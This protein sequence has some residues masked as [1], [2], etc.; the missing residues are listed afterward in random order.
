MDRSAKEKANRNERSARDYQLEGFLMFLSDVYFAADQYQIDG[1][2]ELVC[3]KMERVLLKELYEMSPE[4]TLNLLK[5]FYSVDLLNPIPIRQL[6]SNHVLQSD[7]EALLLDTETEAVFQDYPEIL[8]DVFKMFAKD[9]KPECEPCGRS[10]G[11]RRRRIPIMAKA[12]VRQGC[13][14]DC[15]NSS[16]EASDHDHEIVVRSFYP[17]VKAFKD[18]NEYKLQKREQSAD[19]SSASSSIA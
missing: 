14:G 1:L 19:R 8:I 9:V 3:R 12:I 15:G 2:R 17:G 4:I 16:P 11:R 13:T 10:R 5:K 6:L 18:K 7:L